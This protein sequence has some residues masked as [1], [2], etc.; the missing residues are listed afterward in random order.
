MDGPDDASG[1][2]DF[3]SRVQ[4]CVRPVC[5][6]WWLLALM[7]SADRIPDHLCALLL[8]LAPRV[9]PLPGL[10]GSPSY[11]TTPHIHLRR[12]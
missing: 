11:L 4:P 5:A 10:T 6:A 3:D 7:K 8:R 1:K 2:Y 12:V 9:C